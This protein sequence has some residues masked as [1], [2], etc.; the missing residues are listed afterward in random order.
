M[1]AAAWALAGLL[2][3][4]V[5]LYMARPRF[6]RRTLSAARFLAGLPVRETR[7]LAW[8]W[9]APVTAPAFWLQLLVLALCLAAVAGAAW[10]ATGTAPARLGVWLLVD[11]SHG[12]TTRQDGADRM[13]AARRGARVRAGGAGF[14]AA[15]ALDEDDPGTGIALAVEAALAD[16]GMDASEIDLIV[17][18]GSGSPACDA[19]EAAGLERVFGGRL[20]DIETATLTPNVGDTL[21]GA[22]GLAVCVAATALREQTVPARLAGGGMGRVRAEAREAGAARLRAALVC[23]N[24][25]GGQNAALVLRAP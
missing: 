23:T 2:A 24:A 22:G 14:G 8:S 9:H 19:D 25:L 12:M 16:A 18:H 11:T 4:L 21:A 20:S 10:R 17:P 1:T 13:A 6:R 5:A 15:Q 7:R 3:G